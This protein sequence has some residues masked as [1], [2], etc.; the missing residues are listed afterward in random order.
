MAAEQLGWRVSRGG[1]GSVVWLLHKEDLAERLRKL[2]RREMLSH[3]PGMQESCGKVALSAVLQADGVGAYSFWPRSWSIPTVSVTAVCKQAFESGP[4]CFIFK[5]DG[6]SQGQ[7]IALVRSA[8][9][10]VKAAERSLADAAVIQEYIDRPL[11]LGGHK[12]DAR[13]YTLVM[14][15]EVPGGAPRCFLAEDGLVRVC[16]DPY[17]E[18]T[19]RNLHRLTVHLTNYSLSKFS[20]RFVF[21]EDPNDATIG[22]KRVLSRV[23][24]YLET[25]TGGRVSAERMWEALAL[26]TRQTVDAMAQ[27]MELHAGDPET[28]KGLEK[29]GDC[30]VMAALAAERL[31]RCF[32]ILGL[33]ILVDEGGK[34]WLLEVNNNPSLSIDEVRPL[35]G[36]TSRAQMNKLFANAARDRSPS[37]KWN[38]LCRC[39]QHPRPHTHQ[40]CHVDMHVKIPVVEGAL[41]IARRALDV[42]GEDHAAAGQLAAGTVYRPV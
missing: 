5:P 7:G 22:C 8:A 13:I 14:P 33:D 4:G 26:L 21:N 20:D 37:R 3:I 38:R 6:G 30:E 42:A 12:W 24:A 11:L 10:L 18:P 25:D 2:R 41:V 36:A 39:G 1:G 9:E 19:N 34:P 29:A 17:E 15:S 16:I 23:L 35:E 31:S 27:S 32:Q 40:R 28:W